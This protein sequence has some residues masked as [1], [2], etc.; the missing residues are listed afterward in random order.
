[1]N[2]PAATPPGA[3]PAPRGANSRA[4]GRRALVENVLGPVALFVLFVAAWQ[5]ACVLGRIEKYLLPRPTQVC[6]AAWEHRGELAGATWRTA[7]AALAGFALSVIVGTLLAMVCAQSRLVARSVFP[8][9]IFL[10]TVPIVAIAPVIVTWFGQGFQSVVIVSLV[11]SLFPILAGATSGLTLVDPTLLE[12][13][14]LHNASRWQ[15]LW[16][17]RLP[18]AVPYLVTAAKTSCGL[19]VIG[20]IVGE[21][22]AGYST[23]S[24]ALGYMI[25]LTAGQSKTDLLFAT[26]ACSTLLGVAM[27]AAVGAVASVTLRR[28]GVEP[29]RSVTTQQAAGELSG[30]A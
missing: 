4:L 25:T 8:Y 6:A 13:F 7:E 24:Y 30:S 26:V 9:A 17:L 18:H 29:Q 22:F 15:T 16:K 23:D 10:Q 5:G 28:W 11:I 1:M 19:A 3:G 20:A 12:L 2:R 14:A 27:F 21:F